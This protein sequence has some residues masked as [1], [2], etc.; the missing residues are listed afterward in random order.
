MTTED[1]RVDAPEWVQELENAGQGESA[2]KAFK[3]IIEA[4]REA[5]GLRVRLGEAEE[6]F[7]AERNE[8]KQSL[9]DQ[10]DEAKATIASVE[11]RRDDAVNTLNK[12]NYVL[13]RG[14]PPTA[15]RFLSGSDEG[16]WKESVDALEAL[17]PSAT[18]EPT[19]QPDPAQAAE[20][21]EDSRTALAAQFFGTQ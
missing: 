18:Q 6:S 17:R 7:A 8:L 11:E 3:E 5:N 1:G 10:L 12:T 13:E 15:V 19:R 4:K 9:A 20:P 21:V 2:R 16:E 14:L